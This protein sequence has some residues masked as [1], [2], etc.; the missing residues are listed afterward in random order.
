[1]VYDWAE[2]DLH[3][4]FLPRVRY[5]GDCGFWYFHPCSFA[6]IARPYQTRRPLGSGGCRTATNYRLSA[7]TDY[8]IPIT[9][10]GAIGVSSGLSFLNF[11]YWL[12]AI[13]RATGLGQ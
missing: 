7:I 10:R 1:M 11:G 9:V 5:N 8:R 3:D 12:L 2:L 13:F 6:G 4:L